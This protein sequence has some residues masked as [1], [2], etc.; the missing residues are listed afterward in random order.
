MQLEHFPAKRAPARVT[1]NAG[2]GYCTRRAFIGGLGALGAGAPFA[3]RQA[4]AEGTA[5]VEKPFRID[6]HHHL[7]SPGF[8]AEIA[9]RRTGQVPLMKW[10]VAQSLDDMNQGGVA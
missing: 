9:G 2:A 7:S 6:T 8:I 4:R 10:T 3:G 1:K 5:A